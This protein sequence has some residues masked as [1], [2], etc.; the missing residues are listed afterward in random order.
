[1]K[2]FILLSLAVHFIA[3][4]ATE[5]F[6]VERTVAVRPVQLT[7]VNPD[8]LSFS[9]TKSRL[10]LASEIASIVDPSVKEEAPQPS[11][12]EWPLPSIALLGN[13]L[14]SYP[15]LA[16]TMGWSGSLVLCFV[17]DAAGQVSELE[18]CEPSVHKIFEQSALHAAQSW[19]FPEGKVTA[20]TLVR[21]PVEFR[22]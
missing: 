6:P 22:L 2:R 7:W 5:W 13:Q 3:A 4:I 12:V 9:T 16:E 19:T 14:P 15:P 17:V 11:S 20:R 21:V 18:V 10:G 1:M 8:L